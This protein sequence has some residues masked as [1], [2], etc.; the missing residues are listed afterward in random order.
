MTDPPTDDTEAREADAPGTNGAKH[1]A[2]LH[3]HTGD[4]PSDKAL[5]DTALIDVLAGPAFRRHRDTLFVHPSRAPRGDGLLH[6]HPAHRRIP[7]IDYTAV[8][9]CLIVCPLVIFKDPSRHLRSWRSRA[10]SARART[11]PN[12]RMDSVSHRLAVSLGPYVACGMCSV[13]PAARAKAASVAAE[14]GNGPAV[15]LG[16]KTKRARVRMA[17]LGCWSGRGAQCSRQRRAS[18]RNLTSK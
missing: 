1:R 18:R 14:A 15:F 10:L 2:P 11:A 8:C 17:I 4:V 7:L 16:V 13:A 3:G 9:L 6:H 12:G 5:S